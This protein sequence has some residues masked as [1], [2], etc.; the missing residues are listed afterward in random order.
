[1][2]CDPARR[3]LD[4]LLERGMSF[5]MPTIEFPDPIPGRQLG[6]GLGP[7]DALVSQVVIQAATVPV[8]GV[9]WPAVIFTGRN[10]S[11]GELPKWLYAGDAEDMTRLNTL[12]S[13][14]TAMAVRAA[15][16]GR[17]VQ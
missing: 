8:G 11:G 17:T 12:M 9:I 2:L 14:V 6:L 5:N 15:A 1:V 4:A 7:Q 3:V 16:E 13:D 10:A